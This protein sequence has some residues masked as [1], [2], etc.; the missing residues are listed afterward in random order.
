MGSFVVMWPQSQLH[1]VSLMDVSGKEARMVRLR[2]MSVLRLD[3]DLYLQR[4]HG[5]SPGP[6]LEPIVTQ[7]LLTA[8]PRCGLAAS[9]CAVCCLCWVIDIPLSYEGLLLCSDLSLCVLTDNLR[10][11]MSASILI[12]CYGILTLVL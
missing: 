9:P 2:K 4:F 5:L 10:R 12:N 7:E 6:D 11:Q 1:C 8:L 3:L